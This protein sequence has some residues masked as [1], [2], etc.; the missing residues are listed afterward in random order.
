[1]Q[2]SNIGSNINNLFEGISVNR[3]EEEIKLT[4]DWVVPD[5]TNHRLEELQMKNIAD[6]KS[7]GGGLGRTVGQ[8]NHTQQPR[9]QNQ[10]GQWHQTQ[11]AVYICVLGYPPPSRLVA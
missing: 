1:M 11:D 5:G 2:T 4:L 8:S 10:Q 6:F 7:P 3:E 9:I